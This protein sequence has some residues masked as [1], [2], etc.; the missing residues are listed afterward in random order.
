MRRLLASRELLEVLCQPIGSVIQGLT[1][2][3][4]EVGEEVVQRVAVQQVFSE[5]GDLVA[6]RDG[7][8][9]RLPTDHAMEPIFDERATGKQ[10][11]YRS[12]RPSIK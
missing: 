5:P 12:V 6:P 11:T 1:R 3:E 7:G 4:W 8:A 10:P 9:R 2:A